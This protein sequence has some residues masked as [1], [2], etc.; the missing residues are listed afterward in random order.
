M[1]MF[2]YARH[3]GNYALRNIVSGS[4]SRGEDNTMKYV[5]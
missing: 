2:E 5:L 3:E 1:Q 4:V